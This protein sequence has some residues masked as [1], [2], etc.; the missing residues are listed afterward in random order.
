[1]VL[2][3][4]PIGAFRGELIPGQKLE[5][6]QLGLNIAARN[7]ARQ[8]GPVTKVRRARRVVLDRDKID[9]PLTVRNIR[10]GD[11]FQPLGMEGSKTIGDYLTDRR[12][13]PVFRDEIPVVCD[14]QG[15]IWLVGYEISERVK[16]DDTTRKVI[17]IECTTRTGDEA[18]TV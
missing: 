10:R 14:R 15:I 12:V 3:V 16:I 9:G 13:A 4:A 6:P 5:L 8:S 7:K 1:M 18:E 11:R 17:A 2:V